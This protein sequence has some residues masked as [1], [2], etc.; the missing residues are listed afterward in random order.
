MPFRGEIIG[1]KEAASKARNAHKTLSCT[2]HFILNLFRNPAERSAFRDGTGAATVRRN[3]YE[4]AVE[5]AHL[6]AGFGED[7][8]KGGHGNQ[9]IGLYSSENFQSGLV[10]TTLSLS[11]VR[12]SYPK[13]RHPSRPLS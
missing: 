8:I 12:V 11:L 4:I 5:V 2:A 9:V 10:S 13:H 7:F 6:G 3:G 1:V